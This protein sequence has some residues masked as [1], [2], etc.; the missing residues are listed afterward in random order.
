MTVPPPES[1]PA[2]E[3]ELLPE[4]AYA[5]IVAQL[6]RR[7]QFDPEAYQECCLRRRVAKRIRASG[8]ADS[9]AYLERLESDDAELDAL[10][11]TLTLHVS[12]FFRDPATFRALE[13]RILPDLC[14]QARTAGRAELRL[15]SVGCATGEEAY[16]L[17]LLVDDLAPAGLQVS[18]LGTDVSEP[19]LSTARAGRYDAARLTEVPPAALARYFAR[20]GAHYRLCRTVQER[21]HF[22]RHDLLA[23]AAFPTADLILCRNVLIYFSRAEQERIVARFAAALP[24][25][26]ALVLGGS[27]QLA[28]SP[29]LFRA[30]LPD[31]RIYRRTAAAVEG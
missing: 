27:E 17:A 3:D 8:A 6:R 21:V 1:P 12:R 30:E 14:R 24:A 18:I 19:A 26:G 15:W 13:A 25:G 11:A 22:A 10:L 20:D 5:A 2:W 7:R 9:T 4:A 23:A 31:E 29:G 16:S 28:A